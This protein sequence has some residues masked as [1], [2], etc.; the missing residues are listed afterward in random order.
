MIKYIHNITQLAL[1][2]QSWPLALFFGAFSIFRKLVVIKLIFPTETQ[3]V[4]QM[5]DIIHRYFLL[6]SDFEITFKKVEKSAFENF[7]F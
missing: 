1:M 3:S 2:G 4:H 7:I 5:K 6:E